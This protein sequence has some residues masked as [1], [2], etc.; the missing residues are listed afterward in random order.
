MPVNGRRRRR[1]PGREIAV[2]AA[3]VRVPEPWEMQRGESDNAFHAFVTYRDLGGTRSLEEAARALGKHKKQLEKWSIRWQW[4]NRCAAWDAYLDGVR[5]DE[6]AL[7]AREEVRRMY[8]RHGAQTQA[9]IQ[10]LMIPVMALLR[11]MREP[12]TAAVF[13]DMREADVLSLL[14]L[15]RSSASLLPNLMAAERLV[16]GEPATIEEHR[17]DVD[18][19]HSL[20]E[21]VLRDPRAA[22]LAN[23]LFS[24]IGR[25]HQRT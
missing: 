22:D 25:Q 19:E 23:Q 4:V 1:A 16:R 18:H 20:A 8:E 24:R 7:A 12:E 11:R 9:A 3:G 10:A 13:A 17:I 14:S 6:A 5:R 2:I 15:A 21:D